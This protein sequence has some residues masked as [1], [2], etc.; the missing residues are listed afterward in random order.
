LLCFGEEKAK[1]LKIICKGN[2]SSPL[3]GRTKVGVIKKNKK[4]EKGRCEKIGHNS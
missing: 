3:R 1:E 2:K 4:R